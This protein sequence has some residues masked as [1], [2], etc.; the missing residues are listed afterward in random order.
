MKNVILEKEY[1]GF[2][3]ASDLERDVVEAIDG[4]EEDISSEFT[5]T[6]KVVMTYEEEE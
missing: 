6:I 4:L 3:D 2:E 5:G 1:Y